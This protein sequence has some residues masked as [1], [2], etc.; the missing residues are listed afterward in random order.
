MKAKI[1]A[2]RNRQ[3]PSQFGGTW[4]IYSV[5]F[6]NHQNPQYG[7]DL[8]GFGKRAENLKVG[9]TISGYITTKNYNSKK[10]GQL[11]T[12]YT[13]NKITPEYVYDLLLKVYPSIETM[14]TKKETASPSPSFPTPPVGHDESPS[15]DNDDPGF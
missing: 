11:R 12:A 8:S 5:M 10:D 2:I 7:Y 3:M 13:F 15:W 1:Q 14:S 4:T 9:D 6:E